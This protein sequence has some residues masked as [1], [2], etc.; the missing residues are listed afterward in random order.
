M[1]D[2]PDYFLFI[3]SVDSESATTQMKAGGVAYRKKLLNSKPENWETIATLV[4]SPACRGV[5]AV[6]RNVDYKAF[7]DPSYI[8]AGAALLKAIANR[9]HIILVHEAVFFNYDQRQRFAPSA[10]ER[11]DSAAID[12]SGDDEDLFYGLSPEEVFGELSDTTRESVNAMMKDQGLDVYSYRTNAERSII[13]TRF[14]QN[15]ERHLLF[16]VYVPSGRLYAQEAE[17]LLGLF[18]DWLGQTG[19]RGVRQDGYTTTAGQVFEFYSSEGEPEGGVSRYFE[20]FSSFLENCVS[21]P[22]RAAAELAAFGLDA[23]GADIV[24][25]RFATKAKRLTLDVRQRKEERTL[26]LKHE[27]ENVL[28]EAEG[29]TGS[30]LETLLNDLL[31]T[32][33]PLSL[34]GG[35]AATAGTVNHIYSQQLIGS[36]VGPVIQN[37][38]GT[39]NFGPEPKELLELIA[40]YGGVEAVELQTAVH[41]LEDDGARGDD[42]VVARSRLKRFLGELG[43][44]GLGL[45]LDLVQKYVEHKIGIG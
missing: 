39:A 7:C 8:T 35:A 28:M 10:T 29:V 17:A 31:P 36:V 25:K 14:V 16:R 21:D 20:D 24:V 37:L 19:H 43:Q 38:S 13:A 44:R 45:S 5:I 15:N 12:P 3:G 4:N 11:A 18:R 32:P 41:E 23:P 6:L 2:E 9:P 34:V 42:R 27:F 33:T 22:D 1:T 30:E 40:K 26:T